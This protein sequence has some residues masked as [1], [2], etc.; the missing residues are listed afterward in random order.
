MAKSLILLPLISFSVDSLKNTLYTKEKKDEILKLQKM[1]KI[2]SALNTSR[3]FP[4]KFQLPC[5]TPNCWSQNCKNQLSKCQNY[6]GPCPPCI[7]TPTHRDFSPV[8]PKAFLSM[9]KAVFKWNSCSEFKLQKDRHLLSEEGSH[10][11]LE[12][13]YREDDQQ[14]LHLYSRSTSIKNTSSTEVPQLQKKKYAW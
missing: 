13:N 9:P 10:G 7:T 8:T 6:F 14:E 5:V 1:E 3:H 12:V 11:S 2:F 4:D